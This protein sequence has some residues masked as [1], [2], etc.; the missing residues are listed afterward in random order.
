[1]KEFFS[2]KQIAKVTLVIIGTMIGAGFA[3]G[4]EIALFFYNYGNAGLI[5]MVISCILS[6]III[7]KVFNIL[8]KNH[9]TTYT[10]FLNTLCTNKKINKILQIII[11]IFLLISFYIMVAGFCAF[12]KQELEI[13]I[14][15]SAISI[16]MLCYFT[17]H[18]NIQG[19]I[20][21]NTILM[22]ILILFVLYV[23]IKNIPFT[24][25]YF[26]QEANNSL[27]IIDF[28][29]ILSSILY[30][31]YNSILLI[32]ILIELAPYMNTKRK[33]K[34]A[35]ILC[36]VILL[37]L[38]ICLYCLLLRGSGYIAN[39][40]L[41]II[42]IVKEFGNIYPIFYGMVIIAAIFTSSISAGY[43]FLVGEAKTQKQYTKHVILICISAI[44][45]APIGFSALVNLLYPV[46]GILGLM[47]ILLLGTG[48]Y[49][50]N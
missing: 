8:Q 6:G 42:Q 37:L 1:M 17:F 29:W 9:I 11:Q 25:Q 5:G 31:S 28:K 45:I 49:H 27:N 7:Y 26:S 41:P 40:E 33:I 22:P 20:S 32:P 47:Q 16:A 46:F 2:M 44:F 24:I 30:T 43:G 38:G 35:S 36:T 15:I 48:G 19:V 12:F 34:K 21:I 23:G 3:S 39:L 10:D 14:W 18:K 50:P 4:Q 13:P